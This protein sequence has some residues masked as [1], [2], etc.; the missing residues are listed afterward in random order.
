M[1][2]NYNV[3]IQG[4]YSENTRTKLTP[5]IKLTSNELLQIINSQTSAKA[6]AD[7]EAKDKATRLSK[8]ESAYQKRIKTGIQ[9]SQELADETGA[10]GDKISLKNLPIV[11]KH[12]PEILDVTGMIGNMA[13]G[14]G[15]V[16]LNVEKGDYGQVA[17]SIATPLTVGALAGVGTQNTGQFVNNLANPLAG[18][19]EIIDNLGNKYLP[20]AYKLNPFA[21]KPN[22]EMMYRG[23]GEPA[24]TDA[25]ES[26]IIRQNPSGRYSGTDLFV[27]PNYNVANMYSTSAKLADKNVKKALIEIPKDAAN[28]IQHDKFGFHFRTSDVIPTSKAKLYKQDWLK[29]Y[30]EVP[31]PQQTFKSEINWG[32]WNKEIPENT[33]LMKEYNA[34]EQTTKANGTWMKNPDG[35]TFKGTPEQ[36][37]QQNSENFK[38]AFGNS[39]LVNPDGSPTIQYH[40]SAKKFDTFDESKFQLGDSGYSGVGIYTTPSK[41]TAQSY[42]ISSSKFHSGKIEPTVYELYG[43]ANN[44][45]SSSQLIKENK[46]RDL[47]NFHRK[48]NWKGELTPEESLM[49]FDAA[50]ADQL[51]NVERIR[52]WN[53]AREIVFPSNKQLKSAIG[54]NG[55]FDMTNPNIYKTIVGASV[56]GTLGKNL[57]EKKELGGYV[58]TSKSGRKFTYP[59]FEEKKQEII[60]RILTK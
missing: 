53:D 48:N 38:K 54:N 9:S 4:S 8:S 24:I 26:G 14:L 37:V 52:P 2:N 23:V 25:I 13:S 3:P 15:R 57:I 5:D 30:K 39:K 59:S 44:P 36:F 60:N 6:I 29:G 12:I 28:F 20:N 40:G 49:E 34:I 50:V 10:I 58:R 16:P 33:Q 56:M 41:S 27:S 55:M 32:K 45:I 22:S 46:G 1:G 35:S 11:G 51:P 19:G 47:F 21:F 18:T 7:K 17:L 42:A 31:K 43:Q